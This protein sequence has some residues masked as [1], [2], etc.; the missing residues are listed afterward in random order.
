MTGEIADYRFYENI[1]ISDIFSVAGFFLKEGVLILLSLI[2]SSLL[3]H[4]L[5]LILRAK[6][7]LKSIAFLSLLV[8]II[9]LSTSGGIINNAFST[10]QLKYS[11]NASFAEALSLLQ[12]N[13]REYTYKAK[14]KASPGKNIIVLS[15]ESLEKAYLDENLKHLTPN[16]SKLIKE[17]SFYTMKQVPGGG[18]T[19]ASMYTAITGIP[20]F[21]GVHGNSIF[22]NNYENKLTSL[23]D[24]LN[25]AGYDTQYFLGKKEYSGVDDML[26]TFGITAKSEKDFLQKYEKVDWGIQDMDLFSEFKKE[27]LAKKKSE[28]PFA[29]FLSTI[30]THFPNGVPDKRMDSILPAQKSRLEL[31]VSATDYLIGDLMDFLKAEDMFSNTVFYIYPDHLLMGNASGV[32]EDFNE[33]SLYLLTNAEPQNIG[34]SVKKDIY[35]IDI[36]KIILNGAQIEHNGKFLTDFIEDL[37]KN[38]FLNNNSQHLLRLNEAALKTLNCAEGFYIEMN[39]DLNGFQLLNHEGLVV[40]SESLPAKKSFRRIVFDEMMRPVES[41]EISLKQSDLNVPI[42]TFLDVF[43]ANDDLYGSL[44]GKYRFG[45]T[46]KGKRKLSFSKID[47]DLLNGIDLEG[48]P[49]GDIILNSNSWNAKKA[50]SFKIRDKEENIYRGLTVIVLNSTISE[51]EFKIFDTH[52]SESETKEFISTLTALHKDSVKYIVLAHDS[53]AKSLLQSVYI[54]KLKEL[55]FLKLSALLGR[56]AYIMHNLNGNI[57]EMV[58]DMSLYL[59]LPFPKDIKNSKIYFAEPKVR[60]NNNIDRYIAHAGGTID[61]IKYTD[62][63]EALDYSYGRGFR[64]FELDIIK[65]IEG[66]FIAAHDWGHWKKETGF[67]GDTPVSRKE[68]LNHKIRGKY[69]PLDMEG[70]NKWFEVHPDAILV[71]DKVDEPVMFAKQFVDKKRLMMELFSLQAIEEASLYGVTA[72]ISDIPL[73]Q[74]RGD[75]ISYLKEHKIDYVTMSRRSIVRQKNLLTKFRENNIKVYVYHVNFDKGKDEEFVHDNEIGL[76][77]G[78]YADKWVPAFTPENNSLKE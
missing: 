38:I 69:T 23:A 41:F 52:G 53:A 54:T 18:W 7:R 49:G 19:S 30:S 68:F 48:E 25:S 6:V 47:L 26:K 39:K 37:N 11:G 73:S 58:D 64:L 65:T 2:C 67:D 1:N 36:P 31:M 44:K 13:D 46:K 62:S 10:L 43:G 51:Y 60:F 27:L 71:T 70:I 40:I 56:Q 9:I 8:G 17:H 21:F 32:L 78:M 57:E 14:I 76:V 35:Q 16:L 24:V 72:M 77:Y 63:K 61:G 15:L 28:K 20:G 50:S 75:V 4:Y 22:K 45:I 3:I 74:I 29:L 5:S 59:D 33:R 55:G 34:Y 12:I 66:D 42:L